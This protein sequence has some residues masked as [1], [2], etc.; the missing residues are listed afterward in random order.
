MGKSSVAGR[1]D[2]LGRDSLPTRPEPG[3][4][5]DMA[6]A[7]P[8]WYY[9]PQD[10]AVYRYWDGEGWTEHKSEVFLTTTP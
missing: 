10:R 2:H 7:A 6:N 1:N 9:D 4:E 5:S 3:P 8:G